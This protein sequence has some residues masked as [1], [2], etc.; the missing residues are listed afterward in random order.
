MT[1]IQ[2]GIDPPP[3]DWQ[4]KQGLIWLYCNFGGRW[5]WGHTGGWYGI[6][7]SL[8]YMPEE[9]TGIIVFTNRWV[10]IEDFLA[11][12]VHEL[13]EYAVG[14]PYGYLAGNVSDNSMNPIEGV[15]VTTTGPGAADFTDSNGDY[16]LY[17]LSPGTHDIVFSHED[18]SD[19]TV[20]GVV[21][22]AGDTVVLDV[23]MAP[24]GCDYITGDVNGSD[25]Y[26]GLDITYGV[27]FFKGGPDPMCSECGLCP[28][29]WYCGD[30]NGS[31]SYNGLDITYG[32][33][34]F[35]GG[36]DP[37]PCADCPPV[38]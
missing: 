9:K 11:V 36:P 33:A 38:E 26:N 5:V 8:F 10:S 16:M 29:W 3:D 14:W 20:T 27:N 32:V 6:R 15:Y 28:D 31:C 18:Y 17:S 30:V 1:T 24:A 12:V 19:T 2:P 22:T 25:S 13:L 34:Y 7:T 4:D 37:I 23:Q 35:K 21:V